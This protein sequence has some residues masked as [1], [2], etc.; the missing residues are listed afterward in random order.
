VIAGRAGRLNAGNGKYKKIVYM[1]CRPE[2]N[3]FPNLSRT[4]RTDLIFFC[5]PNNPT[6]SAASRQQLEQLVEFAKANGS[7]I[8]YDSVYAAYISDESPRS[9]FEIPGAKEVLI[10]FNS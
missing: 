7:I 8:I 10:A 2:N 4:P 9:I 5:S 6:G 1:E 3:F